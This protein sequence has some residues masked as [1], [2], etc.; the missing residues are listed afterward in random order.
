MIQPCEKGYQVYAISLYRRDLCIYGGSR[1]QKQTVVP[2]NGVPRDL[3]H[4]TFSLSFHHFGAA[5]VISSTSA[6][7]ILRSMWD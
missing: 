7:V 4:C 5:S 3:W 6:V 1:G 2:G